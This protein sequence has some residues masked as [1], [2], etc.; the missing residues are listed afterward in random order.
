MKNVL[1]S[2]NSM[3]RSGRLWSRCVLLLLMMSSMPAAAQP[4]SQTAAPAAHGADPAAAS[5][6]PPAPANA[7]AEAPTIDAEEP[8]PPRRP[9]AMPTN[10]PP[11]AGMVA[12]P[13]ASRRGSVFELS[14]GPG[15]LWWKIG[16]TS[17]TPTNAF[18][19][20]LGIGGSL[21]KNVA[22]TA[23]IASTI[24]RNGPGLEF[25]TGFIGPSLQLWIGN[26]FWIS[27]G[28]GLGFV[29]RSVDDGQQPQSNKGFGLD[30]RTGCAL[31]LDS[32]NSFNLSIEFVP[33][34]YGGATDV[35]VSSVSVLVGYQVR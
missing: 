26:H 14:L 13:E 20:D 30:V 23:R 2:W 25:V 1:H 11:A 18:S 7:S 10:S 24:S 9:V 33:T 31:P 21:S 35:M 32:R 17:S 19:L 34:F 28:A 5:Q 12:T 29:A 27:G 6:P 8:P 16:E 4:L 22:L 3:T 15:Q